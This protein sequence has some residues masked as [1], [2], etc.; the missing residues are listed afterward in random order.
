M[1]SIFQWVTQDGV[2]TWLIG[3]ITI[4]VTVLLALRTF[5]KARIIMMEHGELPRKIIP[6]SLDFN[7][8]TTLNDLVNAM[9]RHSRSRRQYGRGNS[10]FLRQ[11]Y[12][13][14]NMLT[15]LNLYNL[16]DIAKQPLEITL[17]AEQEILIKDII[18]VDNGTDITDSINIQ[19]V[20]PNELRIQI[21]FINP[22]RPHKERIKL[23]IVFDGY[24]Y[25]DWKIQGR[26]PGWSIRQRTA[27]NQIIRR[28][29]S[30]LFG[31]AVFLVLWWFF[32]VFNR[33]GILEI[34]TYYWSVLET[35]SWSI[36]NLGSS[37]TPLA[38][39]LSLFFLMCIIVPTAV[40][41]AFI[42]SLHYLLRSLAAFTRNADSVLKLPF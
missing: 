13:S 32:R 38:P 4:F 14:S 21:P 31:V 20:A 29:F 26:N 1:Q 36:Y 40:S 9:P 30:D 16:G 22:W 39:M 34:I 24:K 28:E 12:C 7:L 10:R 41:I 2:A 42:V 18:A 17:K 6:Q 25:P 37:L 15:S 33:F 8:E 3:I 35:S 11:F 23:S 27:W 5:P 19:L